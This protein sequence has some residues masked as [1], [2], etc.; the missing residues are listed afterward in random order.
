M[1]F[2][3]LSGSWIVGFVGLDSVEEMDG[4]GG[5]FSILV[6]ADAGESCKVLQKSMEVTKTAHRSRSLVLRMGGYGNCEQ[7]TIAN[8][9]HTFFLFPHSLINSCSLK[10]KM[11]WVQF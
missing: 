11:F 1:F 6:M 7:Y 5:K 2:C 9:F 4:F 10:V 8:E 3:L